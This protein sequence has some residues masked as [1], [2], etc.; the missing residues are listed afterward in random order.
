MAAWKLSKA[1]ERLRKEINALYP[2]RDK[3]SDGAVGDTSHQARKSDHNPDWST[4]GWV[5][6]IDIDEDLN[7]RNG[8]DPVLAD[9]LVDQIIEIA[10]SDKRL[11]YVIFEGRIWSVTSKWRPRKY[12][13][14]N[15]HN[16]HI[17]I[18]FDPSGDK[19]D[20]PFGL[21]KKA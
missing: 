4:G 16:H 20:R 19:D 18:S 6:A 7:G 8:S 17:H 14:V 5:R 21:L 13:G 2:K 3:K 10:K 9:Q 1:A 12:V 15:P 11:K